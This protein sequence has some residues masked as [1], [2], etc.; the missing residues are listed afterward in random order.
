V[1]DIDHF[2]PFND[3][4]G[5]R[6]GDDI[7]RLAARVLTQAADPQVDFVG[8][9]GGDD[10]LMVLCSSDWEER[11]ERVCKAFDAGVRSFFSPEHLAAG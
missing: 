5:Y 10:F 1:W 6:I 8:H 11:L 9:I 3:V 4:Y 7:I 2:K